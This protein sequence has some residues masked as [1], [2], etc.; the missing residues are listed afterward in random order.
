[1]ARYNAWQN[2][3]LSACVKALDDKELHKDRKAFFGS[4]WKTANHLLWGDQLW[5]SRFDGGLAP[6]SGIPD[7]VA[8]H[9]NLQLF[10]DDRLRT[11]QRIVRWAASVKQMDLIGP[12]VWYSGA[13]G[14]SVTKQKSLCIVHFFNHQTH[15]RG[16]LH[17]MLT[18]AG[19]KPDDTDLF[20]MP[21]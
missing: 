16:Q 17:A 14:R 10:L 15:H 11:D 4:I 18:Q 2:K 20:I 19:Q 9:D 1:M 3:S 21:E 13:L 12:M 5:M 7:S 6:S 8:L